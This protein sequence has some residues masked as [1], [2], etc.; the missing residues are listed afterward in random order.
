MVW[1]FAET[2]KS[3]KKAQLAP[4]FLQFE[5]DAA[6]SDPTGGSCAGEGRLGMEEDA[7]RAKDISEIKMLVSAACHLCV[8]PVAL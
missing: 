3:H 2:A 6:V 8:S 7:G 5:C 1:F 4:F